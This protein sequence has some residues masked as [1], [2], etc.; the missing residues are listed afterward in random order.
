MSLRLMSCEAEPRA[1]PRPPATT[2]A[3]ESRFGMT[4]GCLQHPVMPIFGQRGEAANSLTPEP[5]LGEH[6]AD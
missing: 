4:G 5:G 2:A 1:L 6:G 3:S